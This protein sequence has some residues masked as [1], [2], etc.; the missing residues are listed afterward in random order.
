MINGTMMQYFHW[1]I[2]AED[3]LWELIARNA[4]QLAEAGINA[5]WF[6]PAYKAK[7]GT[8]SAGYD[9]YDIY[10]L[11]EFDQ[12]G[13]VRTKYGTREQYEKAIEACHQQGI[14]VYADIVLNHKAGADETERVTVRRVNPDNRNEFTSEPFEIDAYT[15][16]TFPGRKGKYSDFIWDHMCFSGVDY[17]ADLQEDGIFSIM[18]EYGDDWE[19]MVDDE[20]G[21]YDFLM[22]D[23]IEFQQ[24]CAGRTQQ[25]GPLVFRYV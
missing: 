25:M 22:F 21:N 14:Q 24:C 1:Y 2:T 4:P 10:D 12:K 16:F 18:N 3:N 6:P 23:D 15:K 19:E 11:G 9:A 7:E 13:T 5:L 8:N 17:A 20:L